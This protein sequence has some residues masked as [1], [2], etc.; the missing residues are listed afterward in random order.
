MRARRLVAPLLAAALLAAS[1]APAADAKPTKVL[2]A[3][4]YM[5]WDT[6]FAFGA[7]ISEST[8][9]EQASNLITSG[10]QKA[11]Y[12]LLWLDVGWWQGER[13]GN[14][15]IEVSPT[16]WPHGM[17][18]LAKT[19]HGEGFKVGLYTDAGINGCGGVNEGMYGHYQQDI[20]TFAK[21]GFDAV[22]VD[23]CGGD[24]LHLKPSVAYG[25]IHKAIV[26]NSSHRPLMLNICVFPQPGQVGGGFPSFANSTFE[27]FSFGPSDG[28]SWRTDTDVGSPTGITWTAMVRNMDADATEPAAAGPGHWN[29][30]DYL[31]P[32]LGLTGA[33]FQTQFSMWSML[34]AP[35][36]VSVNLSTLSTTSLATLTNREMIQIDQDKEGRQGVQVPPAAVTSAPVSANGEAW[37]KPLEHGKYAVALLNLSGSTL[38]ISTS[39]SAIGIPSAASYSLANVW[40][41]STSTTGGTI[42]ASVPSDST[43]VFIVSP[44]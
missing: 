6:Y 10:L 16:Q 25:Q 11:G 7:R 27:S 36:M 35:L 43:V 17:A 21:W 4:P 24:D 12:R 13:Y 14:G 32:D 5:G 42:S 1:L 22:K 31:G 40:A 44:S 34:A 39:A 9:L 18:W 41:A 8:V 23:F 38:T 19:L 15:Q 26:H 33:Q 37:V 3:T 30:P 20:N 29:D 2:A 28:T